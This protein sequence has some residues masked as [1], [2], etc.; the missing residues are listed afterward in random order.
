MRVGEGRAI[1]GEGERWECG[2]G[3]ALLRMYGQMEGEEREAG[4]GSGKRVGKGGETRKGG[5]DK[6]QEV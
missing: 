5:W 6:K 3:V 1:G 2:G 4:S